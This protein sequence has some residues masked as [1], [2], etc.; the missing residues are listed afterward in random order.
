MSLTATTSHRLHCLANAE[1]SAEEDLADARGIAAY[2][3]PAS[4]T[5]AEALR[6]LAEGIVDCCCS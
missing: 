6:Y 4:D 1:A 3:V 2:D 5:E